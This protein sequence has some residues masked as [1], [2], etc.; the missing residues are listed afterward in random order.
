MYGQIVI[1][2]QGFEYDCTYIELCAVSIIL[3]I[4]ILPGEDRGV[5][6]KLSKPNIDGLMQERRNSIANATGVPSL[7]H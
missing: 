5:L 3:D 7:L 4:M 6:D 2:T 1:R